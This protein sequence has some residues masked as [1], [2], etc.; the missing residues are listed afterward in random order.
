MPTSHSHLE[1]SLIPGEFGPTAFFSR[2]QRFGPS[3]KDSAALILA[4]KPDA[5]FISCFAFAYA[6][7][8]LSLAGHLKKQDTSIPVY[9]GGAGVS[10]LPDYFE[11][12]ESIDG[13]IAGEAE[14]ALPDFLGRIQPPILR[15]T[16]FLK[17]LIAWIFPLQRQSL[18]KMASG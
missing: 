17:T 18:Q 4:E 16:H 15:P 7:D 14:A 2:Y 5:V 12:E 6:D 1:S 10:V 8:T 9:V 11:R 13:V 3:P